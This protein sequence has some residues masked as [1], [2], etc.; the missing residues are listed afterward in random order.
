MHVFNVNQQKL[1]RNYSQSLTF[2]GAPRLSVS[3]LHFD[4]LFACVF[5][6]VVLMFVL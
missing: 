6:A 5:T 4:R 3:Y 1:F 2:S